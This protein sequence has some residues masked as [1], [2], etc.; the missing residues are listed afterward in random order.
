VQINPEEPATLVFNVNCGNISAG[1]PV[2]ALM[3]NMVPDVPDG[4]VTLR[5]FSTNSQKMMY[6][7]VEVL[8]GE[9]LVAGDAAIGGVPGTG[10]PIVVDF[11]DQGGGW[12][13]KL[14]PTGNL[15][16]T[17]EMDDG[18]EVEVTVLDLANL[19]AFYDPVSF[20]ISTG[21]ELPEPNAH[22]VGPPGMEERITELRL[23]VARLI[24]WDQF[25]IDTIREAA[26]PFAVSVTAPADYAGMFG[27]SVR[28]QD[29]DLVARFYVGTLLHTAAPGTGS[30]TLAAAASI[31]GTVPNH[32]L[33]A[34]DL[35]DGNG[36]TFT[37][38]HPS[39]TFTL[40]ARPILT[41]TPND[42]RFAEV[43]FPRTARI[44]CDGTVYIKNQ[45]HP[46]ITV[47]KEADQRTAQSFFL[48]ADSVIVHR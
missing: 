12:T 1:V 42:T 29:I 6:M 19:C 15:V 38:G 22:V 24:G 32:V 28:K 36:G 26:L 39:G 17:V 21:L 45:T 34:G 25:T 5:V 3:K 10:S 8:N 11:R 7:T 2:F 18:S 16:D 20:G 47:W 35:R 27:Q 14:F 23:K 43:S 33:A 44:I 41:D 40:T 48:E 4:T 31:P 9:A 30:T 46:D 13:G 37:Y